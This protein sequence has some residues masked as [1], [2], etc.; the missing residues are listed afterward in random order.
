LLRLHFLFQQQPFEYCGNIVPLT[1]DD[2]IFKR[3]RHIAERIASHYGL[4]G[5]NGIDL[6]ISKKG[7]PYVMEV[8]PR[9]QGT[10]ECVER[11]LGINLVESHV[12]ACLHDY[13]P[14][15]KGRES[16][17]CTRLILYSPNRVIAPDLTAFR[18]VRDV[19]LSG[20]IIEKGEPL[21]SII[22]VGKNRNFSFQKARKLANAIYNMLQSA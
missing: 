18:E 4:Q 7:T 20:C 2:S 21:C 6:V 1:V 16:P 12:D 9:F 8:N 15:I 14:T 17:F 11:V 13:L 19:P 22:T 10:L 3:C 5:S